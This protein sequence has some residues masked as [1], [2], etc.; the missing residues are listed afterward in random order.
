[1]LERTRDALLQLI[2]ADYMGLCILTPG[3]PVEFEW[4]VP[5]PRVALLEQYGEHAEHDFMHKALVH[6]LKVVRRDSEILTR[7]ELER[8]HLYQLSR[9][10]EP[11]LE[12]VMAVLLPVSPGV[13]AAVAFYRILRRRPF[14]KKDSTVFQALTGHLVSAV[15]TC[16]EMATK[17]TGYQLMAELNK[18]QDAE[19]IVVRPPSRERM[20]S[21][22]ATALVEKWFGGSR[23]HRSGLPQ[24]LAERLD[25]LVR[26][27]ATERLEAD[28]WVDWRDDEHLLV[29][30]IE[31]R[32]PDGASAWALRLHEFSHSIPIPDEIARELS[33]RQLEVARGILRNWRNKQIASDLKRTPG[34]VKAHVR[35]LFRELKCDGRLDLMYQAARFLKPV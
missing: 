14:T 28:R 22:G 21:P 23:L 2:P 30:F 18:R 26:M 15:G 17:E 11:R 12:H 9:E 32:E 3:Q 31:L 34:T 24:V 33:P 16:L 5:G 25:A 10:L 29:R 27:S 7:K 19:V 6:Q 4:L 35:D 13:F 8:S 20:R 1:M